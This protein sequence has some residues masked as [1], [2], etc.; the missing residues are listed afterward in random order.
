MTSPRRARNRADAEAL[1][2]AME[3][4]D[5]P[6]EA[7]DE[8]RQSAGQLREK[9]VEER[10]EAGLEPV[11]VGEKVSAAKMRELLAQAR[12][13]GR[14]EA[15]A[16]QKV[17][18]HLPET[19]VIE[20]PDS[21]YVIH[22]LED[23][24]TAPDS[25]LSERVFYRGEEFVVQKGTEMWERVADWITLSN[26]EQYDRWGKLYFEKGP[27]PYGEYDLN[28]PDL[29]EEERRVLEKANRRRVR[30]A[31]QD[32]PAGSSHSKSRPTTNRAPRAPSF[33]QANRE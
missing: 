23:G 25:P 28:D 5:G 7:V 3:L 27:W 30:Y 32:M 29:T 17:A 4:E 6:S 13:E 8:S 9:L 10:A 15:E 16:E 26:A 33:V 31:G 11:E 14:A 18:P 24:L 1:A 12:A 19:T 21:V 2:A 22:F 20:N